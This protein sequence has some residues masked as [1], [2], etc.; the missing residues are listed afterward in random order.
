MPAPSSLTR[1]RSRSRMRLTAIVSLPPGLGDRRAGGVL[2]QLGQDHGE[3]GR[4]HPGDRSEVPMRST[5]PLAVA[6]H[7]EHRAEQPVGDLVEVDVLVERLAQRLVDERDGARPGARRRRGPR[8]PG[9]LSAAAL[10]PQQAA[11]VW[12]LFFTRWWISRIVAS[13]ETSWRSRSRSSVTS[14]S[15]TIAPPATRRARSGMTRSSNDAVRFSI[16]ASPWRAA[17][18]RPRT[19]RSVGRPSTSSEVTAES[20][21]TR[22]PT[23][24]SRR[25]A[26]RALGLAYV[27]MPWYRYA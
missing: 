1:T 7:V 4:D 13:F 9:R 24:P 8:A 22:S 23:S 16:S 21:P 6:G 2:D 19:P 10:Q 15:R 27:T 18:E 12:R 11:T 20:A 3:R 25:N 5:R 26:D 17:G 14:R